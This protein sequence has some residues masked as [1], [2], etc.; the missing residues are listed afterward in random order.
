MSIKTASK[1]LWLAVRVIICVGLMVY[2]VD[3]LDIT[4]LWAVIE[5][6]RSRWPW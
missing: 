2:I 3:R 4:T 5:E 1:R 6:A